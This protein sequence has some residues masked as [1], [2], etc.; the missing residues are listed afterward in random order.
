MVESSVPVKPLEV[1]L[2]EIEV[3]RP[4]LLRVG[5][6]INEPTDFMRRRHTPLLGGVE[7]EEGRQI[8]NAIRSELGWAKAEEVRDIL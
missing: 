4:A 7:D 5:L 3:P 1:W 6:Q 8:L 2:R